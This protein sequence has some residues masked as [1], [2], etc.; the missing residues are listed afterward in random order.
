MASRV[1]KGGWA[2]SAGTEI[3]EHLLNARMEW[4]WE[5]LR[6]STGN[7]QPVTRMR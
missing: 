6:L 4:E 2:G 3:W 1:D 7:G 5:F